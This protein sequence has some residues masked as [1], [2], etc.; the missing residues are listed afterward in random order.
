[1][2]EVLTDP[3]I[4]T[5]SSIADRIFP[6]DE[7]SPGGVELGVVSYVLTQLAGPWG[8]GDRMYRDPPFVRPPHPGHGWQSEMT[9]LAAFS[10]GLAAL[11]DHA[12]RAYGTVFASLPVEAQDMLLAELEQ[13]TIPSFAQLGAADFF[14]LLLGACVEGVF[15][16]PRYGGN[17][18]GEAWL[19][20]GFPG[21]HTADEKSGIGEPDVGRKSRAS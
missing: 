19:W 2:T 4:Q 10:Y 21:P 1:M 8:R 7:E 11:D 9:P 20:I 15:A 3:A 13:G 14:D 16:D 6:P 5:L 18:N 12:V 17:R